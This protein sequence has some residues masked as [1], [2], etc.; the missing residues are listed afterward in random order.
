MF[1]NKVSPSKIK[2]FDECKKKYKFKYIDY[3]K[4]DFNDTLSTDALQFGQFIHK[5]LEDGVNCTTYEELSAIAKSVR[6]QYTFGKEKESLTEVS[7]RN[8]LTFNKPLTE[9]VSTEMRFT[10]PSPCEGYE[11]NGIIDRVVMGKTGDLLV[12]D[13]KTSK[14]AASKRS[15]YNDAQMQMY[16]Y[17]IHKMYD[18]PIERVTVAHYYPHLDKFVSIKYPAGH[19]AMFLKDQKGKVWDI[20]KRKKDDFHPVVNRFCDWC[21]Y[22]DICPAQGAD[23]VQAEKLIETI[24]AKRAIEKGHYQKTKKSP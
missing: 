14:R 2:V 18:V 7:L 11:L 6:S 23:P 22:K 12:I 13:Y 21:G 9:T 10:V 3:L 17:A 16:A 24:K 5:V 19:V 8:F 1:I 15:L 20:R 4:E